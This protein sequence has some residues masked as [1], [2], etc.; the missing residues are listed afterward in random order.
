M[1]DNSQKTPLA[2]SLNLFAEKKVLDAISLLGK[3]LP[4]HVVAVAGQIVTVAFDVANVPFTIPTVKMPIDTWIYDW[5]P[6]QVG[7][8]GLT[9]PSDVYLGG[10]S[11]LGGGTADLST[12]A[13]LSTLSFVPVANASWAP[14][15][16]DAT[17]RVVQGP[18]GVR[19]QDMGG[20]AIGVLD[21]TAGIEYTFA[22]GVFSMTS[23]GITLSFGGHQIVINATGVVIDGRV[24]LS[25]EHSGVQP[26]GGNTAGVV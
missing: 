25:H 26:G 7:T 5:I 15:G 3:A 19:L 12:R 8:R 24:F 10:A 17:K 16:G 1:A 18:T 20:A 4:C 9:V 13:N 23:S 21:E 2:R 14:P 22:G 11:G 6:V